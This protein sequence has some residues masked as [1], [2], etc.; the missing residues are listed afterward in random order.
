MD[1]KEINKLLETAYFR[2]TSEKIEQLSGEDRGKFQRNLA[3]LD[4]IWFSLRGLN[5]PRNSKYSEIE[6]KRILYNEMF[7][8]DFSYLH[9]D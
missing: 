2:D 1:I 7:E 3:S 8:N 5:K 6:I 9:R 4:N